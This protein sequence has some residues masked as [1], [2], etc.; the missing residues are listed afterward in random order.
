MTSGHIY[1]IIIKRVSHRVMYL[2]FKRSLVTTTRKE[3]TMP[4]SYLLMA[5]R[6]LYRV[7]TGKEP[8]YHKGYEVA[9]VK[10]AEIHDATPKAI[11]T[12]AVKAADVVA[13]VMRKSKDDIEV[14]I[15][16]FPSTSGLSYLE[17]THL[18]ESLTATATRTGLQ[19]IHLIERRAYFS[20]ADGQH[21][22]S[23]PT[24]YYEQ[25]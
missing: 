12:E 11:L 4:I 17:I 7:I 14:E 23:V 20:R 13:S 22:D 10:V 1:R 5:A 16:P 8:S 15:T 21:T 6:W 2:S 3:R 25:H 24:E 9:Q 19:F 18:L